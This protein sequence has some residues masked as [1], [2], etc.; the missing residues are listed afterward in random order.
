MNVCMHGGHRILQRQAFQ[1]QLH[2]NSG[3]FDGDHSR[4]L[5]SL[6]IF[7]ITTAVHRPSSCDHD[8]TTEPGNLKSTPYSSATEWPTIPTG[9]SCSHT[10]AFSP[11]AAD[12]VTP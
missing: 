12:F 4:L 3:G 1:R 11:L 6:L 2:P 5:P 10:C 8:Y 7:A 9:P